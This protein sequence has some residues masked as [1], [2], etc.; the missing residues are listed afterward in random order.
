METAASVLLSSMGEK[1]GKGRQLSPRVS[2]FQAQTAGDKAAC[3]SLRALNEV[4]C[5]QY[6]AATSL[7]TSAGRCCQ[8]AFHT[9]FAVRMHLAE[10]SLFKT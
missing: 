1:D 9:Y 7:A 4:V 3:P 5:H 2:G 10:H 8:A 6:G